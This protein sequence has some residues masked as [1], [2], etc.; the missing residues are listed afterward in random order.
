MLSWVENRDN[1]PE[2]HVLHVLQRASWAL[3]AFKPC[4]YP[5]GLNEQ[6]FCCVGHLEDTIMIQL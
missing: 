5:I 4:A 1:A 3:A 6:P 2:C